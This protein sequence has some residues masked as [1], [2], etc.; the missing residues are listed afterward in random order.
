MRTFSISAG[1]AASTVTPGSTA[2]EASRT[3]PAIEA[4]AACARASVAPAARCSNSAVSTTG[5]MSSEH[6]WVGHRSAPVSV[7]F[8]LFL[9]G[10]AHANARQ[11]A[12]GQLTGS[13]RESIDLNHVGEDVGVLRRPRATTDR[14]LASSPSCS[15][16][17]RR[18]PSAPTTS[19]TAR[20]AGAG[21]RCR[22]PAYRS[23]RRRD[24]RRRR[25]RSASCPRLPCSIE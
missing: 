13:G 1:L 12:G 11:I 17:P 2:P 18:L 14:R 9:R 21:R 8:R 6:P 25:H 4:C 15:R 16:T 19:R 22:Q 10:A 23:G 24:R 20:R 7:A 5:E 3:T